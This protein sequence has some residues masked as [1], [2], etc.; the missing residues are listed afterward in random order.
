MAEAAIAV[1]SCFTIVMFCKLC[2][3]RTKHLVYRQKWNGKQ[4]AQ[5]QECRVIWK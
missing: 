1:V 4:V 2:L 5:C 3:R